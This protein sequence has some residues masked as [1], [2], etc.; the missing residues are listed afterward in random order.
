M[1]SYYRMCLSVGGTH[2][3]RREDQEEEEE[4]EEEEEDIRGRQGAGTRK[5]V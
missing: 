4:E 3:S 5:L 1:F 2:P